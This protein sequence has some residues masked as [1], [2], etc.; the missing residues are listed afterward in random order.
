MKYVKSLSLAVGLSAALIACVGASG[1][2]ATVLCKT[3]GTGTPTGTTCPAGWAYP[4]GT[5]LHAVSEG[6]WV[7][8]TTFKNIECNSGTISTTTTN[9]GSATETIVAHDEE[10]LVFEC[11]C[12][13]KVIKAG[14]WEIH[15]IEGTHNGTITASNDEIT[16]TCST[17]FGNVHCIY[18]TGNGV[19]LG[20]LTGGNPATVDITA[21]TPRLATNGLCAEKAEWHIKFEITSPKPLYVT[22]HT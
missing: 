21:S 4:G 17:I 18:S 14:T 22:G 3:P 9:E 16:A 8:T 11:N 1:A 7:L 5:T 13:V 12:E 2:S 15:W 6:T 10:E 19:H 20:T